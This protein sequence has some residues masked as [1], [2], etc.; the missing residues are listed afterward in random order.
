[1]PPKSSQVPEN[2]IVSTRV[3]RQTETLPATGRDDE[4]LDRR[5]RDIWMNG[6]WSALAACLSREIQR[7]DRFRSRY[8]Q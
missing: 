5:N 4:P 6:H 3:H 8:L 1:M 2:A 7:N